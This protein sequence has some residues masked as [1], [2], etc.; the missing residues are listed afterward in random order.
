MHDTSDNILIRQYAQGDLSAFEQL[1]A[2]YKGGI[3]RYLLRQVQTQSLA[4][5]ICQEV[6]GKVI[7]KAQTF[8]DTAEAD[9]MTSATVNTA[10]INPE[11]TLNERSQTNKTS[12]KAWLY[13]I[14]CNSIIDHVRHV[15]VV[16][17]VFVEPKATDDTEINANTADVQS[18][19]TD[20]PEANA[21]RRAQTLAI[22]HCLQQLPRH[23][24]DC[25][26]LKEE[27]GFTLKMIADITQASF[28]ASKSRLKTAYKNL[29]ACLS[30]KLDLA[31]QA[32]K[33]SVGTI[34]NTSAPTSIYTGKGTQTKGQ[35]KGQ[36]QEGKHD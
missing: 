17:Q 27:A 26:L 19:H 30:L 23:Q 34:A 4:E 12:F 35:I 32:P 14:A 22:T 31:N 21:Q 25:F 8:S 9:N 15:K 1:Y 6:W 11:D 29:R 2:R 5:D 13:T 28:E 16:Q 3:Y 20:T 36:E 24:L 33:K 10:E 7:S 18:T